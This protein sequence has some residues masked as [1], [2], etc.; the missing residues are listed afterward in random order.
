[1]TTDRKLTLVEKTT[2]GYFE[3]DSAEGYCDLVVPVK[4]LKAGKRYTFR[5]NVT[6][7]AGMDSASWEVE[8]ER[9]MTVGTFAVSPATGKA[10]I[11]DFSLN[12]GG[13]TYPNGSLFF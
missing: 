5:L 4:S 10:M 3:E 1:M 13:Y 11:T 8:V 9:G 12:I 2:I 6:N 7:D